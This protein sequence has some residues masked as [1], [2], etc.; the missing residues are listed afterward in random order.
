MTSG[1]IWVGESATRW[2]D[3]NL[4]ES[5]FRYALVTSEDAYYEECAKFG[6]SRMEAG[7][8]LGK[9]SGA[10]TSHLVNDAGDKLIIVSID[11]ARAIAKSHSGIQVAALL[12]HEAVH[13]F[14]AVCRQIG[15]DSPSS[16]FEAYSVQWI[17]Q[18][19]MEQ[20]SAQVV[21]PALGG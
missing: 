4:V 12:V 2:C 3:R 10:T 14:Q 19:L 20:Y 8:W 6:V 5:P 9:D 16:E 18:E 13:V 7:V 11:A 17:A 15:E 1:Y 21:K